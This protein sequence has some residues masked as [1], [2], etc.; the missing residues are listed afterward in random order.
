MLLSV[1]VLSLG[2]MFA[3]IIFAKIIWDYWI[4]NCK[5]SSIVVFIRMIYVVHAGVILMF[6]LI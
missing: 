3:F 4:L 2:I 5:I 6:M 1:F